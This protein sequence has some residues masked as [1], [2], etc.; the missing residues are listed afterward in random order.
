MGEC[1]NCANM[2]NEYCFACDNGN[3]F[4]PMTNGDRIRSMSDKELAEV[5]INLPN[6][7]GC[8]DPNDGCMMDFSENKICSECI[9]EWLKQECAE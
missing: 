3:Q 5:L 8:Y 1:K 4:K 6:R 2:D 9:L 7:L